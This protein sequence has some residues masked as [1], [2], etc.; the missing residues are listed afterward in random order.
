MKNHYVKDGHTELLVMIAAR[1]I[2]CRQ[3]NGLALHVK[4]LHF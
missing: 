1:A 2:G 4:K 3:A